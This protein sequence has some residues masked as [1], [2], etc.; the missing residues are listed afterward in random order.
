M[1]EYKMDKAEAV[2][3]FKSD[4]DKVGV[5]KPFEFVDQVLENK[6]GMANPVNDLDVET[7]D[8]RNTVFGTLAVENGG[9]G[10]TTEF[11]AGSVVFATTDGVYTEDNTNFFW[12]DATD[13][14]TVANLEVAGLTPSRLVDTTTDGL[15]QTSYT[16]VTTV[17]DP[18]DD[19]DIPTEQ[20][21]REAITAASTAAAAATAAVISLTR[22][23]VHLGEVITN[24]EEIVYI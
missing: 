2:E 21:V 24:D 1:K 13:T 8:L 19:T 12:D 17:G 14:L 15:L 9:T 22:A 10:T 7:V 18:G 6:H 23:V 11:T 20:A 3:Q 5:R 16:V 4:Y